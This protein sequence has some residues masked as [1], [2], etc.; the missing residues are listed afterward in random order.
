MDDMREKVI[1]G[2]EHCSN[3]TTCDEDCPYWYIMNDP[4]MGIDECTS[5]LTKDALLLLKAQ[6]EVIQALLKV[7]YPHNFQREKPWIVNYMYAIT[8]VIRKAVRLNNG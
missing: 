2:L 6:N 8:E 3:R 1:R 7:G 5:Q 4:D